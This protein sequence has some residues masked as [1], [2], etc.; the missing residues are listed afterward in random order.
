MVC[1]PEVP[2]C[3]YCDFQDEVDVGVG[4]DQC[5]KAKLENRNWKIENQTHRINVFPGNP[6]L[7]EVDSAFP[8]VFHR[9]R[10]V[11]VREH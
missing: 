4:I 3:L 10:A 1:E 8:P 5:D 7:P 2:T 9:L 6:V 11:E